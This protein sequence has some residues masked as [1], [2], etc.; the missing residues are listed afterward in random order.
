ML[1]P[2]SDCCRA[3]GL[4]APFWHGSCRS[5]RFQWEPTGICKSLVPCSTHQNT[6]I[7]SP[8][9]HLNPS[10]FSGLKQEACGSVHWF[11]GKRRVLHAKGTGCLPQNWVNCKVKPPK[12]ARTICILALLFL[13]HNQFPLSMIFPTAVLGGL[14]CLG[15]GLVF[16]T[17]A[18]K[19][20]NGNPEPF[21]LS[22][23]KEVW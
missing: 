2:H 9:K 19:H 10:H 21:L 22:C 23:C 18:T 17:Q 6:W 4:D 15:L 3:V 1:D 13:G 20:Q 12:D 8:R 5:F 14:Q 16:Q 7:L 11:N